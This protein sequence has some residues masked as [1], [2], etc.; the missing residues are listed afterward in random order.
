MGGEQ[1]VASGVISNKTYVLDFLTWYSVSV[2][3]A[4]RTR[5]GVFT[6]GSLPCMPRWEIVIVGSANRSGPVPWL[7]KGRVGT[8]WSR[9]GADG[10][11]VRVRYY[12]YTLISEVHPSPQVVYL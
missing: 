11:R 6:L 4:H 3:T 10:K 8:W 12:I 1:A 9:K 2:S 5:Q 7:S